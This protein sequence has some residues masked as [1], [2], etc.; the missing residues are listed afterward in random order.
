MA[1]KVVVAKFANTTDA[2]GIGSTFLS[3]RDISTHFTD[4]ADF[5]L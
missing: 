4:L 1:D 2:I 3:I 5:S